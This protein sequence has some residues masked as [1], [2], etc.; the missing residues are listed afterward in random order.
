MGLD[1][2][3]NDGE[4]FT[5]KH[6]AVKSAGQC[7]NT[8]LRFIKF[9]IRLFMVSSALTHARVYHN[10]PKDRGRRR[11]ADVPVT[12]RAARDALLQRHVRHV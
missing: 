7:R 6:A 4:G 11:A 8:A 1:K 2:K 5:A 12:L 10:A 9:E 3:Q